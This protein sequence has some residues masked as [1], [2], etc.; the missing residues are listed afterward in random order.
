MKMEYTAVDTPQ[1]NA[2]VEL[3]LTHLSSKAKLQF[4]L[5]EC[6]EKRWEL[7]SEVFMPMTKLDWLKLVTMN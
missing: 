3:R 2:R 4:M 6:P 5:L 7:S 1:L